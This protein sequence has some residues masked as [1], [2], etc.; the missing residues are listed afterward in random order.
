MLN[1]KSLKKKKREKTKPTI[2][3]PQD[4]ELHTGNWN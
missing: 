2:N 1:H 3:I 4:Q